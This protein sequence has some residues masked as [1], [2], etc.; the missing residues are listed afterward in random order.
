[1]KRLNR[2][3]KLSNRKKSFLFFVFFLSFYSWLFFGLDKKKARFGTFS[4]IPA[5]NEL[6]DIEIIIDI[7]HA[8]H[9]WVNRLPY[10]YKCRH[11]ALIA[12][13]MFAFYDI[14]Y[15]IY[16]GF[17]KDKVDKIEGHVWTISNHQFVSGFCN[18]DDYIVQ[19]IFI[20]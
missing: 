6:G 15:S 17:R 11:Q 20:G 7:R 12:S 2:F 18:P 5:P 19:T 3:W 9:F 1:M 16:V 4:K 10:L 14:R 8:I 13:K